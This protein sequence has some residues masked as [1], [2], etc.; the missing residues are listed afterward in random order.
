MSQPHI[1]VYGGDDTYLLSCF[2]LSGEP[3]SFPFDLGLDIA[4]VKTVVRMSSAGVY[5]VSRMN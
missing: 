4:K 1:P 2:G 5:K 3:Q